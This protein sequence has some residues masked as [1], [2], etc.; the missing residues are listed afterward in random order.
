MRGR[1]GR[2]RRLRRT[3]H[4]MNKSL[5]SIIIS[6][7]QYK[8]THIFHPFF[9]RFPPPASASVLLLHLHHPLHPLKLLAKLIHPASPKCPSPSSLRALADEHAVPTAFL[10]CL[11][12]T[13]RFASSVICV[14]SMGIPPVVEVGVRN[15]RAPHLRA[16][17]LGEP[18]DTARSVC[19]RGTAR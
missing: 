3:D 12:F 15:E 1:C 16:R 6:L 13:A 11:P 8:Y 5:A 14:S 19:A 2:V 18:A 7:S 4:L 9:L 10:I 17:H